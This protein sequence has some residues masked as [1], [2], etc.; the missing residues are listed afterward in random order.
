MTS[1][2]SIEILLGDI[3][4]QSVDAIVNAAN[5]DLRGGGGVDGAIHSAAGHGLLDECIERYPDGC[6][7]GEARIT[8][9]H[10]LPAKHVIH[11][12]GP[13]Y[14]DGRSGEPELLASAYTSSMRLAAEHDLV[15][16]AF[17]AISAG[18][19]GYP[20]DHAARIAVNSLAK[21]L[22]EFPGLAPRMVLFDDGLLE[23]FNQ[24]LD[25]L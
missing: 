1:S 12:V 11:T 17:P 16:I 22:E 23:V 6:P 8:G 10:D 21:S 24:A 5:N 13:I 15:T 20:W 9:G 7:T 14:I 4:D 18:V 25:E 2:Q 3:V 19:F